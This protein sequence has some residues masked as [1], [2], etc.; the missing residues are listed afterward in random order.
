M[1]IQERFISQNDYELLKKIYPDNLE[2]IIQKINNNYP[3][4]YLIGYV[5]FYGYKINVDPRVL[6]PRYET[7]GLVDE[8]IKLVKPI[9][10]LHIL[11]VGTGS[12]C[13]AISLAKE[14]NTTVDT[15]DISKGAIEVASN[16][17][18]LNQADVNFQLGDIK[19]CEIKKKYN[20]LV[21]NPPYV[22]YDEEVDEATKYEPQNALFASNNG[23]EFYEVILKRSKEFLATQSI[24]AFEIG[25]T[26]GQEI[27][28]IAR[29]LY[30]KATIYVKKDLSNRDRYLFIINK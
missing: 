20:L 30:P 4:Q 17:A 15:I 14:L 6:I 24:I 22:R 13:I 21:S 26:Q 12:G 2:E 9:K 5:D 27:T 29:N 3:I 18:A 10:N 8:I 11:E 23:L 28:N 25:A 16:N 19:N 7:E 1:K